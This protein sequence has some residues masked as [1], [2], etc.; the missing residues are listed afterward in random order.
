MKKLITRLLG[1]YLNALAVV[2]PQ[3]AGRKGFYLFCHPFRPPMKS[4]HREFLDSSEKF[5]FAYNNIYIQCYRWGHGEKRVLFLHG[6]QSHSF[7]WKNYIQSLPKDEFTIY[8][9]DAP[10]HGFST[11]SYLSVPFYSEVIQAFF[12]TYGEFDTVVG[13]SL[14]SFSII[15][16]LYCQPFLPVNKLVVMAPPGEATDFIRFYKD[17][18]GLSDRMMK[19][20][21]EYFEQE[22]EKPARY[23]STARFAASIKLPGLIIHD[24]QDD[25]T[26]YQYA[27]QINQAWRESGLVTTRG[28]G[29]NLKSPEVINVV[30]NYIAGK[31]TGPE[32][33]FEYL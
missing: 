24:E 1:N 31:V 4:Y 16:A 14:G 2:L 15:Y 27:Q 26:P 21:H 10:G 20:T 25:E 23:F 5:T 29:H 12:S 18:L 9:F 17:T 6:W 22:F 13:H 30:L 19:L 3:K 8:S 11:G 28:L 7:R 33:N 32:R